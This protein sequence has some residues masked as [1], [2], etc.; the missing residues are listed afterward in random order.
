SGAANA[1]AAMRLRIG[2]LVVLG[3]VLC[4]AVRAGEVTLRHHRSDDTLLRIGP[5]AFPGGK[6][7]NL[8]VGIG[9]SA[10]H[11]PGDPP[12]V[13]WTLGDRGPNIECKDMMEVAGVELGCR[14]IK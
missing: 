1:R 7:L 13:L 4:T 10:F 11:H 8:T 5:F 6:I 3:L 14:D 9:S 2:S 12:N